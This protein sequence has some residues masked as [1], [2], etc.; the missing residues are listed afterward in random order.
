LIWI[1]LPKQ[2]NRGACVGGGVD[3]HEGVLILE[4]LQKPS[5]IKIAKKYLLASKQIGTI[6]IMPCSLRIILGSFLCLLRSNGER[7]QGS[8]SEDW[9]SSRADREKSL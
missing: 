7:H 1:T 8:L 9:M 5:F 4:R 6:I 3:D 2:D